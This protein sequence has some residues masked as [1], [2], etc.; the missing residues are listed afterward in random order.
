MPV[1]SDELMAWHASPGAFDRLTPPWRKVE[2]VE[3]QGTI[4]PGNRKTLRIPVAGPIGI[5]WTLEHEALNGATGFADVQVEGP[6]ASWRHEHRFLPDG[7]DASI[8]EDR[9]TWELPRGAS[10]AAGRLERELDRLF[11]FRHERTRHD[12]ARL[13]AADRPLRVAI[14]G[15]S[16]LVGQRLTAFLRA[17]GHEVFPLVR[18]RADGPNEIHWDPAAG[19]ID[20]AKLEGMD[21]VVHL[22][23]AS[24][25]GG[26][27]TRKRKTAIRDSRIH[28]THLLAKTLA[29]L[30]R[31]P[32]VLV[33]TSA[34]GYYGSREDAVLTESS[35]PGEGFLSDVVQA[36]EDAATPAARAG[37]RVVHPRFG[38]VL[39][40]EGGML[41]LISLPF[42]FGA[43]GP[44]GSG[45]QYFSWIAIDDLVGVLFESI[46]NGD[47]E[48]P[49]NAVAPQEATNAEF[50]D[51]LAHVLHRP[52]FFRVPAR[53]MKL[54]AGQL[55]E[56]VILVSQ[57][58]RP[59]RL[60]DSGYQF[61]FPTLEQTLRHELGR[62]DRGNV[63]SRIDRAGVDRRVA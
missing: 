17:G 1:S 60:T 56:E 61:A 31:P 2:V 18:G 57:R 47:L 55:A 63:T 53:A 12:L 58:V 28:G 43:G 62:Y 50:T 37:I 48:G 52:A 41:P 21:A 15:A 51:S 9:L 25:A 27:W 36:W 23:G 44:L 8:L 35:A 16:G 49:V 30:D 5:T 4:E 19:E 40:G 11:S 14:T 6:F 22:A 7:P 32:A 42:R 59:S 38:V 10:V 20:A 24:I 3:Q 29:N 26:L 39:A 34:V 45:R 13:G 33:S 46:V 54:A